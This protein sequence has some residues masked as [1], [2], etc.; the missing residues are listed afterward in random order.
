[1]DVKLT[2]LYIILIPKCGVK[3]V[4]LINLYTERD[5]KMKTH[6]VIGTF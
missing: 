6:S 1:M 3:K 5:L 4:V 2:G